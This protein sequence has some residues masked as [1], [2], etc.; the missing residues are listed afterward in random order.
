MSIY[1]E[2]IHLLKVNSVFRFKEWVCIYHHEDFFLHKLVEQR[3]TFNR[4]TLCTETDHF[5]DTIKK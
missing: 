4:S 5:S 2:R 1:T 3:I